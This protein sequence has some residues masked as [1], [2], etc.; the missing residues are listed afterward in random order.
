MSVD[1]WRGGPATSLSFAVRSRHV[2]NW[3]SFAMRTKSE[4][5]ICFSQIGLVNAVL[6]SKH[7]SVPREKFVYVT[8]R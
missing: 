4:L 6:N 7:G 8:P 2:G 5:L 3:L 1:I